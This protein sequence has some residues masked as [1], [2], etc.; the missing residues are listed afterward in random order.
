M[1]E[2]SEDCSQLKHQEITVYLFKRMKLQK[3]NG[4]WSFQTLSVAQLTQKLSISNQDTLPWTK[5]MWLF[6]QR[7][8]FTSGN[9]DHNIQLKY[10][11]KAKR[12]RKQERKMPSLLMR[13]QITR[14]C[15][16]FKDGSQELSLLTIPYVQSQ[17]VMMGSL[18]AEN[19]ELYW[20]L[21][22]PTFSLQLN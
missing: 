19:Q 8:L 13:F 17:Q 10:L 6:V 18:L 9:T 2:L 12:K 14:T 11:L 22:C 15:M 4:F 3:E 20:N 7:T 5:L 1:L 21:L 16:T